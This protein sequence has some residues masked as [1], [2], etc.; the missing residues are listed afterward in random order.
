MA[1]MAMVDCFFVMREM[2]MDINISRD[3]I[4]VE[5]ILGRAKI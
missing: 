1:R 2:G 3:F 5:I 4:K